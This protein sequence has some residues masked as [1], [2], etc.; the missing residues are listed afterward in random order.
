VKLNS[1]GTLAW[2]RTFGGTTGADLGYRVM[3]ARDGDI[4]LSGYTTGL[5]AGG[6][7][8]LLL[9]VDLGGSLVWAR[10]FGTAAL[11]RVFST[12]DAYD[13]RIVCTGEG[14]TSTFGSGDQQVFKIDY[15]GNLIWARHYGTNV[16][17]TGFGTGI[18]T[19]D[20]GILFTG[21]DDNDEDFLVTKLD[22]TG[23]LGCNNAPITLT[24]GTPALS[25]GSGGVVATGATQTNI[26]LPVG[27]NPLAPI[28]YCSTVLPVEWTQWEV[29]A[30]ATYRELRWR[31]AGTNQAYFRVE[32]TLDGYHFFSIGTVPIQTIDKRIPYT[33][34]DTKQLSGSVGYRVVSIDGNGQEARSTVLWAHP[35]EGELPVSWETP[36]GRRGQLL[37]PHFAVGAPL[38]WQ[39]TDLTGRT[40]RREN[41]PLSNLPSNFPCPPTWLAW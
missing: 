24:V 14:T 3:S 18:E 20:L 25:V 36:M 17:E 33:F 2:T 7:D 16:D 39:L 6:G 13:G 34:L 23:M 37:I 29:N 8:G 19:R 41:F 4:L 12:H 32:Q 30:T 21:W 28:V 22:S 27:T 9:K 11:D 1:N 35:D 38:Y 26:T 31:I 10:T 15:A 40:L 5:G